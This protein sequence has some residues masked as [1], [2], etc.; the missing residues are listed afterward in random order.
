MSLAP[1][2]YQRGVLSGASLIRR[3]QEMARGVAKH[4][5]EPGFPPF[6]ATNNVGAMADMVAQAVLKA[7]ALKADQK[8]REQ[9]VKQ[10]SVELRA[11][12]D[13]A[14]MTIEGFY[15][16]DSPTLREF[17]LRARKGPDSPRVRAA[18]KQK[19]TKRARMAASASVTPTANQGGSHG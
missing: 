5:A 16:P 12:Y 7:N 3:L 9:S 13:R 2:S 19:R 11:L 8:V 4:G 18:V 17:G 14:V 15:G 6:F 1:T 10:E